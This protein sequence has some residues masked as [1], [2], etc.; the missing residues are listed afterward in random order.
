MFQVRLRLEELV[1][2]RYLNFGEAC[3]VVR[4]FDL[5]DDS[6]FEDARQCG[7][8]LD[9]GVPSPSVCVGPGQCGWDDV[10]VA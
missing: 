10:V 5:L 3:E 4:G 1:V 2:K 9:D 8:W 6:A 7:D